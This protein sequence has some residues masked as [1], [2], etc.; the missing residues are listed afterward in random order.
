MK[1]GNFLNCGLLKQPYAC[2][3]PIMN[4]NK[5]LCRSPETLPRKEMC[6]LVVIKYVMRNSVERC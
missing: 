3:K 6:L 1:L 2:L 4:S 5:G